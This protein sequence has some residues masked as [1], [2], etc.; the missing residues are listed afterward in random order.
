MIKDEFY[1][2][3][4]ITEV[5]FNQMSKTVSLF[6]EHLIYDDACEF[7]QKFNYLDS[8]KKLIKLQA[9]FIEK[10]RSDKAMQLKLSSDELFMHRMMIMGNKPCLPGLQ[11]SFVKIFRNN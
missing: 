11:Q 4:A 5:L 2:N 7:F 10:I 8:S 1:S 9:Q 6:K 3:R